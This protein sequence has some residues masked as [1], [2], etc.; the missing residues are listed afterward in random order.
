MSKKTRTGSSTPKPAAPKKKKSAPPARGSA[1]KKVVKKVAKNAVKKITTAS[2]K[3]SKAAGKVVKTT[4]TAA[5]K[6]VKAVKTVKGKLAKAVSKAAKPSTKPAVKSAKKAATKSVVKTAT[7][8][9]TKPAAKAPA[10]SAVKSAAKAAKKVAKTSLKKS[11][12][13][14][15]EKVAGKAV[16]KNARD[17][18]AALK[19][20][21]KRPTVKTRRPKTFSG[22][23]AVLPFGFP[24]ATP[25][26]PESYGEDRLVL[27][28]KDPE[29]L[30]AYWEITPES[31]KAG[32][33]VKHRG[34]KYRE[35]LRLNWTAR[36]IFDA[37][38]LLMPVS[39]AARKWYLRVPWSGL[40][41]Q[42]E[43]G[44]LGSRGHFIALL[45]SNP[46]D[47]PESWHATRRRLAA[48]GVSQDGPLG[49]ALA[50]EQPQGSSEQA[51]SSPSASSAAARKTG[52]ALWNFEGPDSL[53]SSS[54]SGAR[55]PR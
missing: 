24:E 30:F 48:A 32:E 49:R 28:A 41:Y 45:T 31:L 37:N 38:Y 3:V 13:K 21:K 27:M 7:S 25:E 54:S 16:R 6:A 2:A 17:L 18:A 35:A 4:K 47:A 22:R 10:K 8:A 44:W 34:E 14:V 5:R 26:L 15:V 19:G 1:T 36:D 11:V 52:E 42:I 53:S 12:G 43:I 55:K 46:S 33:A 40:A 39:L 23:E 20:A 29:Y 50:G 51:P 9:A